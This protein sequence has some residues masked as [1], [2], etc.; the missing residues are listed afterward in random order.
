M[1]RFGPLGWYVLY[2]L[3]YFWLNFGAFFTIFIFFPQGYLTMCAKKSSK[4]SWGVWGPASAGVRRWIPDEHFDGFRWLYIG[5]KHLEIEWKLAI[6]PS[7]FNS[8]RVKVVQ[9]RSLFLVRIFLHSGRI[10]EN[11]DQK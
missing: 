3:K 7:K 5:F 10:Q 2:S 9:I 8:H 6:I 4:N 1:S 11:T